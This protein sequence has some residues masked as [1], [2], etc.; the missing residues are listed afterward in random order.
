SKVG[1]LVGYN[2]GAITRTYATGAVSGSS[3]VGG[4]VGNNSPVGRVTSSF[5]DTTTTGMSQGYG[6]NFY[7][8]NAT[9]LTTAQLQ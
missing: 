5:W 9:G 1:G 7:T 4:L 6:S 8:F 3:D 2:Q